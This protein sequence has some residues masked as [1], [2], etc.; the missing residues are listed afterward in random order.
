ML[1]ADQLDADRAMVLVVDVQEKL[2]PLVRHHDRMIADATKLLDGLRI[3]ELPVVATEQY[4]K[5]LGRT[6]EEVRRCLEA[7]DATVLEKPT[8]SAWAHPAVR[9]AILSVDRPQIVMMGIE[10]HVCVQQTTLDLLSRDYD[11]FVCAD[12]VGSRGRIDYELS[13][14]R[15]RQGGAFVT[16]V[17]SV[18]FELCNRCDTPQFK[19][20]IE[21]IKKTPPAECGMRNAEL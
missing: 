14:D 17:E 13:L 15:M 19:T 3:F 18:L 5:G 8:F 20:M 10:A 2:V 4:P 12:A 1:R 11:V 6:V 9:D 16:T 21:V 7:S